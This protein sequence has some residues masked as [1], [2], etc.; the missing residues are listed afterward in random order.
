[1]STIGAIFINA[2]SLFNNLSIKN[3]KKEKNK[4]NENSYEE[5]ESEGKDTK[6]TE[7]IELNEDSQ[8]I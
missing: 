6:E 3:N 1:M 5:N 8:S 2:E 4:S 7:L